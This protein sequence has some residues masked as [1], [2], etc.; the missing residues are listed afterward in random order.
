MLLVFSKEYENSRQG[1]SSR[2]NVT[3]LIIQLLLD[4]TVTRISTNTDGQTHTE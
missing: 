2:T 1:E 3:T 4:F